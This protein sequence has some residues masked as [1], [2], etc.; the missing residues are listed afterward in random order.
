VS[1]TT[2][3]SRQSSSPRPARG[4]TGAGGVVGDDELTPT[5][6]SGDSENALR[7][8]AIVDSGETTPARA[9]ATFCSSTPPARND[10]TSSAR[11]LS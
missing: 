3:E 5:C 11:V 7:S 9:A 6:V 1:S 2:T 8:S 10:S 4:V